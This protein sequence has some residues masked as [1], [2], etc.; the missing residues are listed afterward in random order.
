MP[1]VKVSNETYHELLQRQAKDGNSMSVVIDRLMARFR[2]LED[3]SS[4]AKPK[5][6]PKREPYKGR[7]K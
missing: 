2:E 1:V 3:A 7:G 5:P 4:K 6:K